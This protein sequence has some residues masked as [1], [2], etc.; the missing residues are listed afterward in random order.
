M[1]GA[2]GRTYHGSPPPLPVFG[3]A[4]RLFNRRVGLIAALLTLLHPLLLNLSFAVFSEGHYATT[5][6]SAVY[7]V[8][9]ALNQSSTRLWLLVGGAF[10]LSYLLRVEASA[11]F[12]IAVL[13]ALTATEGDRTV[14]CKRAVSAIVVFLACVAGSH[15]YLQSGKQWTA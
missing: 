6:L 12:A 2:T 9:R 11:A 15:L 14:K 5:L 10:G 3:I 13:F 1:G 4:S 7:I 8:V